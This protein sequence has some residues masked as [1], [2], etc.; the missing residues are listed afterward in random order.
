MQPQIIKS[1]E[2]KIIGLTSRMHHHQYEEIVAL[3]KRFMPRKK[4]LQTTLNN[5]L[6]ALQVYNNFNALEESFVIWACAEVSSFEGMPDG[7]TGF[8]IPEG[9]YAVFLHKGMDVSKTYQRI[10]SEWL[11]NSGYEI[12]DRPH[13]QI[14]GA[15]YMNGSSA[16]EEDLFIPIRLKH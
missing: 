9:D 6:I 11:P 2:K 14:M 4:E 1:S 16:S 15:T 13:F 7:M 3:W 8:T 12:D 5:E 10:M